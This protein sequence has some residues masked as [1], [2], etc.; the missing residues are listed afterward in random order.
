MT[1]RR[2]AA[3]FL[4][5]FSPA[6]A[7]T[8]QHISGSGFSADFPLP[9]PVETHDLPLPHH[10]QL[11]THAYDQGADG[12]RFAIGSF[13]LSDPPG[14]AFT[15]KEVDA[16]ARNLAASDS[17]CAGYSQVTSFSVDGGEGRKFEQ[18]NC[19]PPSLKTRHFS[20]LEL[21]PRETRGVR[22][23]VAG[24]QGYLI[25]FA[26]PSGADTATGERF[27]QSFKLDGN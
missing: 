27:L 2:L 14:A 4:A 9:G 10:P 16:Y 11:V 20:A 25:S 23:V 7:Q 12:A 3:V 26:V 13:A 8:V 19:L 18:W 15:A 24:G 1:R 22:F 21:P 5:L 6:G 17:S